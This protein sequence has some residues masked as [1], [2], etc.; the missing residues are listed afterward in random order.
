M[1]GTPET[2]QNFLE[3]VLDTT[4]D[5]RYNS[6]MENNTTNTTKFSNFYNVPAADAFEQ[7]PKLSGWVLNLGLPSRARAHADILSFDDAT[8]VGFARYQ[9]TGLI[10]RFVITG[11]TDVS[12]MV[13]ARL[14]SGEDNGDAAGTLNFNSHAAVIGY[15]NFFRFAHTK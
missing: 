14:T 7:D 12:G 4:R 11:K 2:S 6:G 15:A 13:R 5:T 8:A 10:V 1:P 9:V 3:K